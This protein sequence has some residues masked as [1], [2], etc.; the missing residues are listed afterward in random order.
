MKW[1]IELLCCLWIYIYGAEVVTLDQ[2]QIPVDGSTVTYTGGTY[3]WKS[4]YYGHNGSFRDPERRTETTLSEHIWELSDQNLNFILNWK[5]IEKTHSFNPITLQCKLCLSEIYHILVNP[6]QASLNKRLEVYS[7]CR[8]IKKFLL[9]K[10]QKWE[11]NHGA[12]SLKSDMRWVIMLLA[13]QR[14]CN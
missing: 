1:Q 6:T 12:L 2:D 13:P 7:S 8:H 9:S 4:R 5:I 10:A 11:L 3:D 14:N